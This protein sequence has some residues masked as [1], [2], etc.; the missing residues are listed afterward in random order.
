MPALPFL[1]RCLSVWLVLS[2]PLAV[3]ECPLRIHRTHRAVTVT[4]C[5]DETVELCTSAQPTQRSCRYQLAVWDAVL[6]SDGRSL[7][8]WYS[9]EVEKGARWVDVFDV[10][11]RQRVAHFHPG[12]GGGFRWSGSD[13]LLTS[14]CGT[15]CAHVLLFSRAGT[16]L[17]DEEGTSL[18]FA[19]DLSALVLSQQGELSWE[20]GAS[21]RLSV[22]YLPL[23]T[24]RGRRLSFLVPKSADRATT[25]PEVT[26]G[27]SVKLDL[28]WEREGVEHHAF[29]DFPRTDDDAN[30]PRCLPEVKRPA[31]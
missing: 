17:L 15:D 12:V 31:G 25:D 22:C 4:T 1:V 30:A 13:I 18:S 11:S 16:R 28:T 9:S 21:R 5:R 7:L 29:F 10:P 24:L 3:A 19:P 27:A 26:W 20:P 14:G 2:A 23:D 8:V 6:S